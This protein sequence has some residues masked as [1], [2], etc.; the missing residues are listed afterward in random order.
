MKNICNLPCRQDFSSVDEGFHF[1]AY[2]DHVLLF[3]LDVRGAC[4]FVS[5][6]WCALTG[7]SAADELDDGWLDHVHPEDRETLVKALADARREGEPTRQLFRLRREDGIFRWFVAQGMPRTTRSGEPAGHIGICF[8]VTTYQEGEAAVERSAQQMIS[9]LR[10]T[11]LIAVVL[12]TRG[13]VQFS[14]GS[15]CRLLKC[16]GVELMDCALFDRYLLPENRT[17]L[18]ELYPEGGQSAR[19]PAE[20]EAAMVATDGETRHV[21]WH[22]MTMC[23][24]SGRVRNTV[25]VGDDITELRRTEVELSLSAKI[26]SATHHAIVVTGLDGTIVAVND[27]FTELTGYS[28]EEALGQNPRILQSG[29]HDAAFYQQLWQKLIDSGHWYGD[30]WDRRKD[31]SIYPKYLSIS[32]IRDADGEA[33]GYSGIFY[34]VSERKTVEEQLDRLAHYDTLTGLSNRCQLLERLEQEVDRASRQGTQVGLMYLD[35]DHFKQINDTL[36]HLAGDELLKAAAARMR[37]AVRTADTVAR[38]GGDEFVVVIPDV[39]SRDDLARVARKVFDA[40]EPPYEI[41]GQRVTAT[42]SIGISVFPDDSHDIHALIK[43]ADSAMYRVK[44]EGRG[45]FSFFSDRP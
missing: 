26:F 5:P 10:Q 19:F 40:L 41:E 3:M 38:L 37:A 18:A 21:A 22:A 36:G 23:D 43:H 32:V 30:V 4:D 33:S 16:G 6:S 9:L 12:D 15:L 24:F 42:A 17:L 39:G 31:G 11:R 28:R 2:P 35:L 29:R 1:L 25:L 45:F 13:R 34:D 14:N 44:R 7:R 27:A 8:D 20:F